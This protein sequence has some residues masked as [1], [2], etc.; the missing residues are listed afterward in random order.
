MGYSNIWTQQYVVFTNFLQGSEMCSTIQNR[1]V[2]LNHYSP[3]SGTVHWG[4]A[5][6]FSKFFPLTNARDLVK[7]R[8][9]LFT[10]NVFDGA[11]NPLSCI[12]KLASNLCAVI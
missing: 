11:I 6:S 2:N 4:I 7:D 10:L 12:L 3:S 5:S 9:N 8:C 1:L